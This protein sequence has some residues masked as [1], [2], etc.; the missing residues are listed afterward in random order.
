MSSFLLRKYKNSVP[1]FHTSVHEIVFGIHLD[2]IAKK[3][4]DEEGLYC[5]FPVSCCLPIGKTA[6]KSV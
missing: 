6:I 2:A 1:N 3:K 4:H 5:C